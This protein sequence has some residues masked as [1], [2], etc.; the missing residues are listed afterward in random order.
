MELNK[1][2][3]NKSKYV[4]LTGFYKVVETTESKNMPAYYT[5]VLN[6]TSKKYVEI[7]Y[8]LPSYLSYTIF[9]VFN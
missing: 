9:K 4:I 1:V 8:L 6:T 2:A 7:K 5:R 3:I